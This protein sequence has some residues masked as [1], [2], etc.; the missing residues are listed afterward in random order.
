MQETSVVESLMTIPTTSTQTTSAARSTTTTQSPYRMVALDL[1]GTLLS[2]DHR[3][4][5]EQAEYLRTLHQRGFIVCLATGRSA[6]S[7]YEHIRKLNIPQPIPVVCSNGACG[8]EM[9]VSASPSGEHHQQQ[10]PQQLLRQ[11]SKEL[12]VHPV[13][14]T[15]V[16]AALQ[17]AKDHGFAVQYYH[18]DL[19]LVNSNTP[20]HTAIVQLYSRLTGS[21][22]TYVEDDFD[23]MLVNGKLP[24]KLLV[25]FPESRIDHATR[26]Y[27][28][29]LSSDEAT[30]VGGAFDWFLEVLDPQVH[31]GY[32]LARMCEYLDVPLSECIAMG[33]GANDLEFLQMAGLGIAMKNA[34]DIVK[35]HADMALEWTNVEH[36]VMR[37]LER[38]DRDGK[39]TFGS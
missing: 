38:L 37:A 11:Q 4:A 21:T 19:I 34:R 26:V 30:I 5:D 9:T 22:I 14:L 35:E 18:Q 8:F 25:L 27:Q 24:S 2:D 6:P 1:D 29:G 3:I 20:E 10:Q 28:T 31:K 23:S 36:G 32:G 15:T 7:V 39:L 16:Q 17:L 33:D 12:F 13:S